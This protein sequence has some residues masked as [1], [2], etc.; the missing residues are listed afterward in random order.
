MR[1]VSAVLPITHLL[2][3]LKN[4]KFRIDDKIIDVHIIGKVYIAA[5]MALETS[6]RISNLGRM[7]LYLVVFILFLFLWCKV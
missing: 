4:V 1:T 7:M 3:D 5:C 6:R 2:N